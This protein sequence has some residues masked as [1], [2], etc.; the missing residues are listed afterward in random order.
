MFTEKSR[1]SLKRTIYSVMLD[2]KDLVLLC[3][4]CEPVVLKELSPFR[5]ELLILLDGRRTAGEIMQELNARGHRCI[6]SK[7]REELDRLDEWL[8]LEEEGDAPLPEDTE[9]AGRN[10]RTRLWFAARRTSGASFARQAERDLQSA[11]IVL[12][13]LGGLGSQLFTQLLLTGIGE[14]TAVDCEKVEESNLNR[15]SLFYESNVGRLKTEAAAERARL[16]NSSASIH[17][18]DKRIASAGDFASLMAPASLALL[19]ADTPRDMIFDWMNEASY[20]TGVPVLY[21]NGVLQSSMGIGPLVIPGRT[22]CYQCSMPE[23]ARFEDPLVEQINRRHCHG[24][25]LPPLAMCAGLMVLELVRHLTGCEPC[26]IYD[27]RLH[28]DFRNYR[29]WFQDIEKRRSCP[30]CEQRAP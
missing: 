19:A 29:M 16:M 2:G 5:R 17:F 3:T 4:P 25:I 24:V 18:V 8:L 21:S 14:I 20:T 23:G 12:F 9:H 13:G 1:L 6:F 28:M 27:R 22:A 7:V 30:F 11:H 10:D 26:R 15:Q